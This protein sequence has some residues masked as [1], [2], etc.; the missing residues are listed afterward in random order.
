MS[1]RRK[2]F[3][4][5]ALKGAHEEG[6][7]EGRREILDWLQEKYLNDP[8][9]PD[10]GTPEAEA[11]LQLVREASQHISSLEKSATRKKIEQ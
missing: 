9:R 8:D 2:P 11:L 1:N 6:L 7:S 5:K 10:R 4:E 3:N